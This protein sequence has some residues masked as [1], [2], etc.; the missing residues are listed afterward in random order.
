M[1]DILE[2][3]EGDSVGSD[4]E[5]HSPDQKIYFVDPCC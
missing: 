3:A 5:V 2:Q 4:S 1:I